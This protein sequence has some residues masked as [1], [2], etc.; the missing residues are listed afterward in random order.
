MNY[1]LQRCRASYTLVE[2]QVQAPDRLQD[3]IQSPKCIVRVPSK[4]VS[5]ITLPLPPS[6]PCPTLGS[7][8]TGDLQRAI[9][10]S[11]LANSLLLT[12]LSLMAL[13][14]DVL[15]ECLAQAWLSLTL[16]NSSVTISILLACTLVHYSFIYFL[17]VCVLGPRIPCKTFTDT[18]GDC[19]AY[20][21]HV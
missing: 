7:S 12:L 14:N 9:T 2:S 13:L 11:G 4:S 8:Q 1:C 15:P 17:F 18:L 6:L 20:K 3:R 19:L 10:S 5:R 21:K 16:C